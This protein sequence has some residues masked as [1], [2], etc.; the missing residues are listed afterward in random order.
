[1]NSFFEYLSGGNTSKD[2]SSAAEA[3]TEEIFNSFLSRL[4][5]ESKASGGAFLFSPEG[6]LQS[7]LREVEDGVL[8]YLVLG[9]FDLVIAASAFQD[10]AE[11]LGAEDG[12]SL[13]LSSFVYSTSPVSRIRSS[14]RVMFVRAS[15]E[16]FRLID[17]VLQ[18]LGDER[19]NGHPSKLVRSVMVNQGRALRAKM[20]RPLPFIFLPV[21]DDYTNAVSHLS[22]EQIRM[23]QSFDAEKTTAQKKPTTTTS[24]SGSGKT[25][26]KIFVA[27]RVSK[28]G[29]AQVNGDYI[30]TSGATEF[31]VVEG[32]GPSD[33]CFS[34][35]A[36]FQLSR[37]ERPLLKG[38]SPAQSQESILDTRI[39]D[40]FV[41]NPMLS[42]SYY[43]CSTFY[44][45]TLPPLR[46]VL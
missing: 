42:T 37:N 24:S 1:M 7:Y 9:Q 16:M 27:I 45:S 38:L 34:N 23:Q 2:L 43:S 26:E 18:R 44:E 3:K 40:W 31:D 30:L 22:I 14:I 28:C 46:F 10:S 13:K 12:L 35:S 4:K 17:A 21:I 25:K 8:L 29:S 11:S 6:A 36:G 32:T 33:I 5:G 20:K 15:V 39:F 19:D 41:I